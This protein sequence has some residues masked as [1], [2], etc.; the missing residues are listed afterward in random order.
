MLFMSFFETLVTCREVMCTEN[1]ATWQVVRTQP[2]G[3]SPFVRRPHL[4]FIQFKA[5]LMAPPGLALKG[6]CTA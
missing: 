5:D 3:S 1:L 4:T 6:P 2:Q